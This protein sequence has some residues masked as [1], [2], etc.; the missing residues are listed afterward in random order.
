MF[1]KLEGMEEP[2]AHPEPLR[3]DERRKEIPKEVEKEGKKSERRIKA[4]IAELRGLLE[5]VRQLEEETGVL[6]ESEK[7]KRKR[8][9]LKIRRLFVE[10]IKRAREHFEQDLQSSLIWGGAG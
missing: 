10:G 3:P 9:V 5:E 8:K 1:R 7:L 2:H 6:P 4:E